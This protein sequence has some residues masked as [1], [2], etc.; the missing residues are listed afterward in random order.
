MYKIV[1]VETLLY[2]IQLED[3][4]TI[5]SVGGVASIKVSLRV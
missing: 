1:E 3:C 4:L 5:L 2:L